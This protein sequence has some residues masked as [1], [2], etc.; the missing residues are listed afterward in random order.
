MCAL[1]H[2]SGQGKL[3][4][5]QKFAASPETAAP[6]SP[7]TVAPATAAPASPATDAAAA[8][9]SL[10]TTAPGSPSIARDMDFQ[11]TLNTIF[12]CQE[13]REGISA[14]AMEILQSK[15]GAFVKSQLESS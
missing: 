7:T 13:F 2:R 9:G 12:D 15:R 8:P 6:A 5:W 11:Q 4:H 14:E 3:T 1:S 10:A